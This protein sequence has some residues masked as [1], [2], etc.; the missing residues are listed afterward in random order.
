MAAGIGT[1]RVVVAGRAER[2]ES[3]SWRAAILSSGRAGGGG[4]G[5]IEEDEDV[6]NGKRPS[7]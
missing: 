5:S 6:V 7:Y 1:T 3:K 4:L 2:R